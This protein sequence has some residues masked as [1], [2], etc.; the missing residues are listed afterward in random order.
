[1]TT[2]RRGANSLRKLREQHELTQSELADKIGLTP[3]HY[4]AL[5][6]GEHKLQP[7]TWLAVLYVLQQKGTKKNG[8]N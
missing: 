4:A 1:M 3:T 8:A 7:Q 2:Y 5:E 6:R